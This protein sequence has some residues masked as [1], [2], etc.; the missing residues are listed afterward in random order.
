MLKM[1]KIISW[2]RLTS[3]IAMLM[4]FIGTAE[5]L[6]IEQVLY[7]S[8]VGVSHAAVK[9]YQP[10]KLF[11]GSLGT[12]NKVEVHI[13][14]TLLSITPDD[15]V[16]AASSFYSSNQKLLTYKFFTQD[17]M[18]GGSYSRTW[19]I[20]KDTVPGFLPSEDTYFQQL[21]NWVTMSDGTFIFYQDTG[22]VA[23]APY[24]FSSTTRL[25]YDYTP[26]DKS[27]QLQG[28]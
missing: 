10:F 9:H 27:A 12:L 15:G 11:D 5:A 21:Q 17:T 16:L 8:W 6:T 22:S 7:N 20:T 3:A 14:T 2:I 23:P 1:A 4:F 24:T 28:P 18:L 25:V 19:S 13:D 26:F